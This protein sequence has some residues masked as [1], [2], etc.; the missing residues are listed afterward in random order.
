MAS[1]QE[2]SAFRQLEGLASTRHV[3]T[4]MIRSGH[5][6]LIPQFKEAFQLALDP[7]RLSQVGSQLR[8]RAP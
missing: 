3:P 7:T 1:D 6:D 5:H 2:A 4:F 8:G